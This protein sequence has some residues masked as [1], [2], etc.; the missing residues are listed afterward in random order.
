MNEAISC[1]LQRKS[2]R[3]Y[4]DVAVENEKVELLL[5]AAMAAPSSKNRQPWQFVAIRNK[6]TLEELSRLLPYAKMVKDAPLAIAICGDLSKTKEEEK[7]KWVVDC[8]A[9]TENLLIAV[10]SLGLGAVW[11]GVYPDEDRVEH[12]STLLN[13]PSHVIPL[14]IIPIGYPEGEALP[15]DKYNPE[16]IHWEKWEK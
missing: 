9:A 10:E 3:R 12:V 6:E 15:R 16:C 2:V 1:I 5:R 7:N 4:Q 14:N 13:L 11:T 8:S